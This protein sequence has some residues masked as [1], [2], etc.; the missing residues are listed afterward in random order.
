MLSKNDACAIRNYFIG[1][2]PIIAFKKESKVARQSPKIHKIEK[3][4]AETIFSPKTKDYLRQNFDV[5]QKIQKL[6]F[7]R[8]QRN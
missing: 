1:R 3:C 4:Q 6:E 7:C 8:R 5:R 2:F